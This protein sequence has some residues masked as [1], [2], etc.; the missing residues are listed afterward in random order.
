[1]T[2]ETL[3]KWVP[4]RSRW[5]PSVGVSSEEAQRIKE[6]ER[7]N[8]EL[9]RAVRRMLARVPSEGPRLDWLVSVYRH[10][11]KAH[12]RQSPHPA[13]SEHP[14]RYVPALAGESLDDFLPL[15]A[16]VWLTRRG[17]QCG[18]GAPRG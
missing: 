12:P 15:A 5:W 8:E 14:G 9:R 3:H 11:D 16:G 1:M 6:L 2:A 4:G 13:P 10:R 7:E 17:P 18:H